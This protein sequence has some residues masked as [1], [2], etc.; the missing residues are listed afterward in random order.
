M[1]FS[2]SAASRTVRVIGPTCAT[3]PNGRERPGRHAAEGR[4]EPEDAGEARRDADR[5]AAVGA[6]VQARPCRQRSRR[7]AAAREP[8]GVRVRS[9]GLRVMP[10]SGESVTPF[11]PNSGVVVLP[12]MT[13]P[14]LAQP[15]RPP[16][17]RR[18]RPVAGRPS[19]S[20]AASASRAVRM[21][22]LIVTG[23]PSSRPCGAPFDP[24]R[25]GGARGRERPL[26]IDKAVGVKLVIERSDALEDGLG[27]LHRREASL[28]VAFEQLRRRQPSQFL[29]HRCRHQRI[30]TMVQFRPNAG[31]S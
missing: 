10:V 20:R 14:S 30:P 12:S 9:Q 3:V 6:D 18:P 19:A 24:A 7:G 11:Q 27:H 26:G 13:A 17:H 4:L 5:A 29:R 25:L 31:H 15:G 1:T 28:L 22:S 23:T 21:R 2:I 16:A 8:P